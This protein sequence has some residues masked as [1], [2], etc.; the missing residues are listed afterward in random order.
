MRGF[1]SALYAASGLRCAFALLALVIGGN[2]QNSQERSLSRERG[3]K[4]HSV[5]VFR[6]VAPSLA[7]RAALGDG[8][9][10][11]ND[12]MFGVLPATRVEIELRRV[13][14]RA[15][16]RAIARAR[17]NLPRGVGDE[18]GRGMIRREN[19]GGV[20]ENFRGAILSMDECGTIR[21]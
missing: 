13:A 12:L 10:G 1:H 3:P 8:V 18:A 16:G 11:L 4:N 15:F 20:I 2:N 6:S 21:D 9:D 17:E 19:P 5:V 7:R 14:L